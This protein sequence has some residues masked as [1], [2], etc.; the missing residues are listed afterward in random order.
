M[1]AGGRNTTRGTKSAEF[2]SL[3]FFLGSEHAISAALVQQRLQRSLPR[4]CFL[5]FGMLVYI[6][7]CY[8]VFLAGAVLDRVPGMPL[9]TSRCACAIVALA[10]SMSCAR[11]AAEGVAQSDAEVFRSCCMRVW[12]SCFLSVGTAYLYFGSTASCFA[13]ELCDQFV[14][15]GVSRHRPCFARFLPSS[16]THM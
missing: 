8:W 12:S 14:N 7:S 9:R 10:V 15:G 5:L 1:D 2:G 11:C 3:F 6:W 16:R 13:S 4:A